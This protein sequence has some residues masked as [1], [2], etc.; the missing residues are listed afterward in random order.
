MQNTIYPVNYK[1]INIFS[2][3]KVVNRLKREVLIYL[4]QIKEALL[5]R[6]TKPWFFA[7]FIDIGI[8]TSTDIPDKRSTV[9]SYL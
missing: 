8:N 9:F 1:N 2:D 4:Q 6:F 3:L 7:F 5:Y